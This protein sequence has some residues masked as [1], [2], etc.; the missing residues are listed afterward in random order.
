MYR[1]FEEHV[2]SDDPT[3]ILDQIDGKI[4]EVP[5][6]AILSLLHSSCAD[7][8][9]RPDA[10]CLGNHLPEEEADYLLKEFIPTVV[11]MLL[12]KRYSQV[13]PVDWSL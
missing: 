7:Q 2:D 9:V 11:K 8:H 13:S 4:E 12:K 3:V 10:Q 6:A 5:F 1:D